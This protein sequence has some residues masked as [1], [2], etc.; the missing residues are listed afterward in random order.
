MLKYYLNSDKILL[1]RYSCQYGPDSAGWHRE[2]RC[3]CLA[4]PFMRLDRLLLDGPLRLR[5]HYLYSYYFASV[6]LASRSAPSLRLGKMRTHDASTQLS[7]PRGEGSGGLGRVA[8]SLAS[9]SAHLPAYEPPTDRRS[10]CLVKCQS[11][12]AGRYHAGSGPQPWEPWQCTTHRGIS[13]RETAP[14]THPLPQHD[15]Q[16]GYCVSVG[17]G[18]SALGKGGCNHVAVCL[19]ARGLHSGLSR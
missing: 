5:L 14:G 16:R 13:Q 6:A 12:R 17:G 2:T 11:G 15:Q 3:H 10:L 1:E 18:F 9:S 4:A 19:S 7:D 8:S